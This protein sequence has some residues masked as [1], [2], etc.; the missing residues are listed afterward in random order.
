M[1]AVLG[2][3]LGAGLVGSP[4]CAGMCGGFAAACGQRR[5]GL[6]LWHAGRMTTY[7]ALGALAGGVGWVIPGPAWLP[8]AASAVLLVWF[9]GAVAGVLP[10]PAPR[11][12][13][14]GRTGAR[15]LG[16]PSAAARFGFGALNGLLPCGMVYAALSIPVALADPLQGAAA[17]VAFG[18]GTLPALTLLPAAL[19][20]F[21]A[22]GR[23]QRRAIGALVLAAGLW[24]VAAR[25]SPPADAPAAAAGHAAHRP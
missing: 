9:A 1:L 21:A 19:Q 12:G 16:R 10:E 5:G 24:S 2:A 8:A 7:A 23:W 4:H 6:A 11:L 14:L 15:L 25:S 13:W 20:S 22:R 18:L 17:M 3:A